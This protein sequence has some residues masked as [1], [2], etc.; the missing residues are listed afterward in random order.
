MSL[1]ERHGSGARDPRASIEANL[2]RLLA[3]HPGTAPAQ[4]WLGVPVDPGLGS[5]GLERLRQA[6]AVAIAHGEPR[7]SGVRVE[8]T[9]ASDGAALVSIRAEGLSLEARLG[10]GGVAIGKELP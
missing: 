1:L 10:D 3:V 4:P 9:A 2:R 5:A 8:A 6:V 7:L